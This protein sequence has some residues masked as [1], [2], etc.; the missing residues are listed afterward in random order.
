MLIRLPDSIRLYA[1]NGN[2]FSRDSHVELDDAITT[3][4]LA[5]N[6][7]SLTLTAGAT[8]VTYVKLRWNFRENEKPASPVRVYG[9]CWERGYGD[10]QWKG[11]EPDRC[12]PWVCA[13][14][15]GTKTECFGVKTRPAALCFW[16]YDSE[17]VTL[18]ADVRNG[19]SGVIL[20]GRSVK[21]CEILFSEGENE[22][23]FQTLKRFYQSLN[24]TVLPL[25][26]P[27]YGSNNWYYAYGK[28]SAEEILDDCALISSLTEGIENRP[29]MVID[30]GWDV[31]GGDGLWD[32]GGEKYGDMKQLCDNMRA[33]GV[34]PGIWVRYLIDKYH[35]RTDLPKE[36]RLMRDDT[37]LDP[38]HPAVI[39]AVKTDTR[40]IVNDWG[41]ELIKHDFSTFDIFGY[42]G[43][44][45]PA[46]FAAD[47]WHFYDRS[48]TTAEIILDLYR[49]IYES[50]GN[51]ILIGCNTI[52]H[53]AAG[54]VHL[55][56]TGDDTSGLNWERT[57]KYGVNT[58]AF[59]M[60]HDKAFYAA[61]AD[62]VGIAGKYPF[63]PLNAEWLRALSMSGTPLFIS[64]KP[65]VLTE[66]ETALMRAALAR[67]A[68]QEDVMEP[69][70]WMDTT[71]PSHFLVNGKEET[72][73]WIDPDGDNPFYC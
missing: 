55:N 48:R 67:A 65:G 7:V 66:S 38:S 11:I 23:A 45:R 60:L 25:S 59:R 57:R 30:A 15:N 44:Q 2:A 58:L 4:D 56:R 5:G 36:A 47:G 10:L 31:H 35:E 3:A 41:Y 54:L 19:G 24:D 69:V 29:Y 61:D 34:R 72:F 43:F 18:W 51:A 50:A 52:G 53:L 32:K 64:L 26:H 17:G 1:E 21:L 13:S 37:Y 42:W 33:Q 40:R 6:A 8:P 63:M 14:S 12:M 20:N 73:R 27:V 71:C 49:A 16:K 9:D 46:N 28:S 62:C 39:E 22:S 70:D 68:K